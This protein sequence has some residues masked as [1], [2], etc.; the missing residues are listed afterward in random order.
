MFLVLRDDEKRAIYDKLGPLKVDYENLALIKRKFKSV[1]EIKEEYEKMVKEREERRMQ[2]RTN[3]KGNVTVLI[4]ATDIFEPEDD[5]DEYGDEEE[6]EW[7]L[8]MP[9]LEVR[10]M[11]ITHSVDAPITSS[12]N[13]TLTSNINVRNGV[14]SGAVSVLG[15][16]VFSP[17]T[18]AEVEIGAGNGPMIGCKLHRAI[19]SNFQA[20]LQPVL[21]VTPYGLSMSLV[22]IL[23]RQFNRNLI[24]YITWKTGYDSSMSTVGVYENEWCRVVC[25]VTLNTRHSYLSGSYTHKFE[26]RGTR[27][28]LGAKYGLVGAFVEW[29]GETQISDHSTFGATLSVGTQTGVTLRL[30]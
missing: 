19:T 21:H 10:S 8:R 6:K 5:N 7:N 2:Q 15:R 26:T 13:V 4:D 22:T 12:Y 17:T 25:S 23:T 9:Y 14:G 3:P 1:D 20:S 24:G 29:G 28:K 30:K 27:I 18:W 16:S 11:S